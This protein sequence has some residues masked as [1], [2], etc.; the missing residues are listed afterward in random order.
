M[1]DHRCNVL[2]ELR[3]YHPVGKLTDIVVPARCESWSGH[4]G[5]HWIETRTGKA[6]WSDK[7]CRYC[8]HHIARLAGNNPGLYIHVEEAAELGPDGDPARCRLIATAAE[9]SD[10]R[11]LQSQI[12]SLIRS[13]GPFGRSNPWFLGAVDDGIEC[14]LTPGRLVHFRLRPG[15]A[16]LA[17][18]TLSAAVTVGM[19]AG[20]KDGRDIVVNAETNATAADIGREISYVPDPVD[21]LRVRRDE[22][23]KATVSRFALIRWLNKVT[24]R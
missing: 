12:L 17:P 4:P 15:G 13:Q 2:T 10:L 9:P 18:G 11:D 21:E 24:A 22:R 23:Q 19:A 16:S 8:G 20:I 3:G 6:E 7:L 5:P 1:S 14:E